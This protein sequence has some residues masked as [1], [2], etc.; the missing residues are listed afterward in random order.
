MLAIIYLG[1]AICVG[2]RLCGHFYRFLSTAHR[3]A[4]ATLVGLLLS[5]SATL[6]RQILC[7]GR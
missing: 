1:V 7:C 5:S 3:W 6:Y 4:T 2:D